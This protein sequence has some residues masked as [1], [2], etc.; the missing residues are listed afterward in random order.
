M[1]INR[2]SAEIS[3]RAPNLQRQQMGPDFSAC[4]D[5]PVFVSLH[6][7]KMLHC[8][9]TRRWKGR[10]DAVHPASRIA[11]SKSFH[12]QDLLLLHCILWDEQCSSTLKDYF[13]IGICKVKSEKAEGKELPVFREAVR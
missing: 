5:C 4:E 8:K 1:S 9:D 3:N 12:L 10:E 11:W 6:W 2:K 13:G 7:E